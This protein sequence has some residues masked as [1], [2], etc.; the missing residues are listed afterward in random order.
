MGHALHEASV[1]SAKPDEERETAFRGRNLPFMVKRL[2]KVSGGESYWGPFEARNSESWAQSP[3]HQ[4]T[5]TLQD[6][7][8]G[9]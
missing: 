2:S 8:S 1:E 7:W 6:W 5:F 9:E 3:E 4:G